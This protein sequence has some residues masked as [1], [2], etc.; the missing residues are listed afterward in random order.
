M[1]HWFLKKSCIIWKASSFDNLTLSISAPCQKLMTC[2]VLRLDDWRHPFIVLNM[3]ILQFRDFSDFSSWNEIKKSIK[4]RAC[5]VRN[6]N[7]VFWWNYAS[8]SWLCCFQSAS[9]MCA[10]HLKWVV[11]P[12]K[13]FLKL[14]KRQMG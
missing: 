2:S 8:I 11:K 12:L 1:L 3:G 9:A 5:A 13:P 14:K 6:R 7:S 10:Q 4:L